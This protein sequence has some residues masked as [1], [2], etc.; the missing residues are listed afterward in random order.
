MHDGDGVQL[1]IN[2]A[3]TNR[4]PAVKKEA[5]FWLG[6]SQDKRA[7]DYLEEILTK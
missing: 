2:V 1:L 6:Q 4:N 3:R 7:L 5:I